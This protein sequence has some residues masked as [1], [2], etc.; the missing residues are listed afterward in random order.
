MKFLMIM[1]VGL[2]ASAETTPQQMTN[3]YY[4]QDEYQ[5]AHSMF[6]KVNA[7]LNRAQTNAHPNNL[8]DSPRF[9]IAHN[10]L[11][12]LE[13]SWD[14]A[15]FDSSQMANTIAALRMVENDNR[16]MPHDRDVIDADL[17]RLMDFQTEYY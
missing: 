9:D 14:K 8:G 6:D 5:I 4:S 17:S 10:E 7:D 3:P 15:R 11:R 13:Q 1:L 2:A 16:L 12:A